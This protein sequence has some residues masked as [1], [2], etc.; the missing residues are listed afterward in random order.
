MNVGITEYWMLITTGGL[1]LML[2]KTINK[3]YQTVAMILMIGLAIL[4]FTY[5]VRASSRAYNIFLV[6]IIPLFSTVN[7]GSR[8]SVRRY[9]LMAGLP[10]YFI[11]LFKTCYK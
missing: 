11:V 9:A 1:S 6:F 10:L 2:F 3:G 4:T 7:W 5:P 8:R